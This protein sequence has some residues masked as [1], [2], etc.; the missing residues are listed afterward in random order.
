MSSAARLPATRRSIVPKR[1]GIT[2]VAAAAGLLVALGASRP[3]A[4]GWTER[5]E[6]IATVREL[7]PRLRAAAGARI[8]SVVADDAPV[9]LPD[10]TDPD[11]PK[12]LAVALVYSG[13]PFRLEAGR[14]TVGAPDA[15]RER[16]QSRPRQLAVTEV[17]VSG[18]GAIATG[19]VALFGRTIEAPFRV[20][21]VG[22]TVELNGVVVFPSP[23]PD[24]EGPVPTAAQ[25]A[26]NAGIPAVL[27]RLRAQ[28]FADAAARARARD[29][30]A[31]LPGVTSAE[32]VGDLLKLVTT[33]GGEENLYFEAM[34]EA[35]PP[36][37]EETRDRLDLIAEGLNDVLRDGGAVVAG[38]TYL[39]TLPGPD[40]LPF[41]DRLR[42]IRAS[43]EPETLK[44]A[45]IQAWTGQRD[46]AADLLYAR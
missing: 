6:T 18:P 2:T 19:A 30:L 3:A 24:I 33:D 35:V 15:R 39:I 34:R 37:P 45:R 42:E 20:E 31:R 43:S 17:R 29:D 40:G 25:V 41:R 26:Q 13:I 5:G 22:E 38:A 27:A 36:T 16:E 1:A 7:L 46:A 32:W 44:L 4:A 21:R 10:G 9:L 8:E 14:W 12:A 11:D 23:G 28:P